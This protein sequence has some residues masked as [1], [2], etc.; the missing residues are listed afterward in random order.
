MITSEI[1]MPISDIQQ[2]ET[3]STFEERREIIDECEAFLIQAVE[4]FR[5]LPNSKNYRELQQKMLDFQHA[6]LNI[7]VPQRRI[8]SGV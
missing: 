6:K 5:H 4:N 3:V 1:K 8:M 2:V 7:R